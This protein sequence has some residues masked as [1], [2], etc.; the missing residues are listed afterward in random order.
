[1]REQLQNNLKEGVRILVSHWHP[2]VCSDGGEDVG[3]SCVEQHSAEAGLT[4]VPIG[5]HAAMMA[6]VRL[7][8][9]ISGGDDDRKTSTDAKRFQDF[10]YSQNVEVPVK[11]I[12]GV[13]Y[14]RVSCH[15]YN[16]AEEF[17]TL[18]HVALRYG[19]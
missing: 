10:L 17:D 12:R 7:P 1:M 14:V 6:L 11:C 19:L 3:A 16:T 9:A 13:L 2:E 5:I 8:L 15:V 4:L 18:A